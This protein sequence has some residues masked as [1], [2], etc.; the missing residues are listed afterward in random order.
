MSEPGRPAN[1]ALIVIGD[2]ILTGKV[3]DTN[4]LFLIG[5]LRECGVDL[6][7][8]LVVSDDVDEIAWAVSDCVGRGFD[9]IFT[10]GGIGPTHDDVTSVGIAQALGRS[11]VRH[12]EIEAQLRKHFGDRLTQDHLRMAD[13]PEGTKLS[14]PGMIPWP[15]IEPAPGLYMLPG[16][17]QI[18]EDKVS[19]LR[20]RL[21]QADRPVMTWVYCTLGE[22]DLASHLEAVLAECPAVTI[23]SYPVLGRTDYK[24]RVSVESRDPEAV[25]IAVAA[26][27]ARLP[28]GE[29]GTTPSLGD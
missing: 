5:V 6:K 20:E 24:V 2:E 10:S 21:Q 29:A 16:I 15:V 1:A 7:R 4:S 18:F 19:A 13:I 12:P 25:E 28:E 11:I 17:P 9:H 8:I 23:G 26:L 27:L 22:G 14:M 3:E